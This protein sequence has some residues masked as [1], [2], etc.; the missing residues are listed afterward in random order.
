M[1]QGRAALASFEDDD[2]DLDTAMPIEDL[3]ARAAAIEEKV[4]GVAA[5]VLPLLSPQQRRMAAALIREKAGA[6]GP[7]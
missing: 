4:A 1:R 6:D 5:V 2:F 3:D 7:F